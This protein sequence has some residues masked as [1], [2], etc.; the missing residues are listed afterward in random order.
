MTDLTRKHLLKLVNIWPS[1]EIKIE[2]VKKV[3]NKSNSLSPLKDRTM[4]K[5]PVISSETSSPLKYNRMSSLLSRI[6]EYAEIE[7]P[8]DKRSKASSS[9]SVSPMSK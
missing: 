2:K 8:S 9:S 6:E 3:D 4:H 7:D 1:I 5:S